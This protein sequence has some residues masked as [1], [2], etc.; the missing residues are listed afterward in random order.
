MAGGTGTLSP[1]QSAEVATFLRPPRAPHPWPTVLTGGRFGLAGS[2]PVAHTPVAPTVVVEVDA[3]SYDRIGELWAD[4]QGHEEPPFPGRLANELAP[5]DGTFGLPVMLQL[6]EVDLLPRVELVETDHRLRAEQ[7]N[8][9]SEARAQ[10]LAA[11]VM[12]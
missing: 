11:T 4:E 2:E 12:H 3:D 1:A 5:F 8:G 10:E 7:Q 6:R 9:I